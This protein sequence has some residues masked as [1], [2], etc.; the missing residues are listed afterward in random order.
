MTRSK[1]TSCANCSPSKPSA[2]DIDDKACF[3]KSLLQKL[4]SLRFIFYDQNLHNGPVSN[5][6]LKCF[7]LAANAA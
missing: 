2:A 1:S 5:E 7:R 6:N 3:P 4:G